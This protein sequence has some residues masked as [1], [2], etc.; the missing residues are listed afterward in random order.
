MATSNKPAVRVRKPGA[1]E[2]RER[3]R[4]MDT[5]A[6]GIIN[7]ASYG[8]LVEAAEI[9]FFRSHG[10]TLPA[11]RAENIVMPRVHVAYDFFLPAMLDDALVLRVTVGGVGVHSVRLLIDIVR[12]ED[13]VTLAQATVI[14][15]CMDLNSRKSIALPEHLAATLR[16]LVSPPTDG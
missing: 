10:F 1:F 7:F 2:I 14:S 12:A 16:A 6:M 8:R 15:S 5:D 11:M 9:E 3:V 4:L 13:E